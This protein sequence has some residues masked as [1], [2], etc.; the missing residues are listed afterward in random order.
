TTSDVRRYAKGI[1]T[2]RKPIQV[3]ST[4]TR[5]SPAPR[6]AAVKIIVL[7]KAGMAKATS[8]STGTPA[9]TTSSCPGGQKGAKRNGAN[10]KKSAPMVVMTPQPNAKAVQP[11]RAG[12]SG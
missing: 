4:G 12:C 7:A 9:F 1:R 5:V 3:K 8:R 2:T 10:V 6:R 11:A